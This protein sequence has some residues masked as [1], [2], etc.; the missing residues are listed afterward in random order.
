[1]HFNNNY[2]RLLSAFVT[3]SVKELLFTSPRHRFNNLL[4]FGFNL[5]KE[6]IS[7]KVILYIYYITFFQ[8]C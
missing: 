1:M 2:F 7:L 6:Y 4:L 3:L 5:E 8:K